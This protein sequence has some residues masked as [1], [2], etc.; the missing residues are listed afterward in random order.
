MNHRILLSIII[1]SFMLAGC[2]GVKENGLSTANSTDVSTQTALDQT[3]IRPEIKASIDKLKD[4]Y[5]VVDMDHT[6]LGKRK[7]RMFE[8]KNPKEFEAGMYRVVFQTQAEPKNDSDLFKDVPQTENKV[9]SIEYITL[10]CQTEEEVGHSNKVIPGTT[11]VGGY[12]FIYL[13]NLDNSIQMDEKMKLTKAEQKYLIEQLYRGF[14]KKMIYYEA[15]YLNN[16]KDYA[17]AI[18]F[19]GNKGIDE[20]HSEQIN[21]LHQTK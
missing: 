7:L 6:M 20:F 14:A 4:F 10:F 19:N 17:L 13:G 15:E 2:S 16:T 1:L 11:V 8:P 12:I 3:K 18:Y 21:A 5:N 9:E